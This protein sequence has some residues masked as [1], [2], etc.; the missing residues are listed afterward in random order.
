MKPVLIF[1]HIQTSGPGLFEKFLNECSIPYQ[2]LRPNQ[3]DQVPANAEIPKYSG[4]CFLG[5]V[6]SVTEPTD[7]MLSEIELIKTAANLGKPMIGH[8]LGGQLI[9][10]AF[11]GQVKKHMIE[12]FGWSRLHPDNKQIAQ[13][14]GIDLSLQLTAMQWHSDTFSI[15]EGATRILKGDFCI[16]QAFVMGNTLAMQ[17]HVEIDYEMIKHWAIDLVEKHPQG[18]DSVQSGLQIMNSIENNFAIS[19]KL[20]W[21]LYN[22]WIED[23]H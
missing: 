22:K 17:F 4:F 7:A 9:S 8:C 20:A 5:G 3:G 23:L 1:E 11:G 10:N 13:L 2:I 15:P 14:W 21:Q 18:N 6:E 16:N 19:Q 12:E